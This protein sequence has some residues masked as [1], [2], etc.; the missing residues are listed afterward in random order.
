MHLDESKW[1]KGKVIRGNKE[2][3]TEPGTFAWALMALVGGREE[4]YRRYPVHS[5]IDYRYYV[6][7][8]P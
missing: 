6:T 4:A 5:V 3:Y 8:K 7:F 1:E 2:A